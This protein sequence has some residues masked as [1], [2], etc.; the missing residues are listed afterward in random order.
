MRAEVVLIQ[1]PGAPPS[2]AS[3][4]SGWGRSNEQEQTGSSLSELTLARKARQ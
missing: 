4:G 3:S 2:Q 1:M